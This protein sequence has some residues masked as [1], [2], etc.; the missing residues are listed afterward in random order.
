MA[1]VIAVFDDENSLT[2]ALD[3][4][5]KAGYGNDVVEV[6]EHNY[7]EGGTGTVVAPL[8]GVGNQGAGNRGGGAVVSPGDY[9]SGLGD[10]NIS[11]DEKAFFWRS[12]QDG[13]KLVILDADDDARDLEIML[14][15][16]GAGR[17]QVEG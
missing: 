3:A 7:Q 15:Q 11:D 13:A 17:V 8:L 6:I 2:K 4:L 10:A 14:K 5:E 16:A 1:T 12:V 9:P